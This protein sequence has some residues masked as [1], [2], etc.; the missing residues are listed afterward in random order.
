MCIL[1]VSEDFVDDCFYNGGYN[2]DSYYFE[3]GQN[4]W[5]FYYVFLVLM[6]VC[7]NKMF[8]IYLVSL[9]LY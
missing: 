7:L 8:Y 9:C 5:V 2:D 6:G 1:L 3:D 4:Y